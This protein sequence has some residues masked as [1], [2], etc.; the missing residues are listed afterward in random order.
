LLGATPLVTQS[1]P[2]DLMILY[3]VIYLAAALG[4][5]LRQF[6]RRDM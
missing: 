4:L 5:A 1:V 3:A 2:S 6:S